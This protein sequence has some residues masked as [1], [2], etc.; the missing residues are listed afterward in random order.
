MADIYIYIYI[1]IYILLAELKIQTHLHQPITLSGHGG[2]FAA[3]G[4]IAT[5]SAT[6][7]HP[8]EVGNDVFSNDKTATN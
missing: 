2:G 4:G 1:Y 8:K 5:V 3:G 6:G 7:M